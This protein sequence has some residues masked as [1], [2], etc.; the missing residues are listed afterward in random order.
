M[1]TSPST[2]TAEGAAL[3][4]QVEVVGGL[5]G[6]LLGEDQVRLGDQRLDPVVDEARLDRVV[7]VDEHL[8]LRLLRVQRRQRVEL[9]EQVRGQDQRRDHVAVLD[10]LLG[11][12]ARV[13]V[14]ALDPLAELVA[15]EA[16]VDRVVAAADVELAVSGI[17]FRKATR[18]LEL[19]AES[20][21]PI[22]TPS[23]TG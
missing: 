19:S 14:D 16:A 3:D 23:T 1:S 10:L 4:D 8:D 6:D 9:V 2:G 5:V 22:S 13:D 21:N 7:L 17:S 15:G 11:L 18:G 12:L 20:A